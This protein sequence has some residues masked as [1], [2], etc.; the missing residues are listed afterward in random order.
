MWQGLQ[1]ICISWRRT[2]SLSWSPTGAV[3]WRRRTGCMGSRCRRKGFRRLSV[4][5]WS[6]RS[7]M[8]DPAGLIR[9]A[10]RPIIYLTQSTQWYA[11]SYEWG[12]KRADG[13]F[14]MYA[15][16]YAENGSCPDQTV[17]EKSGGYYGVRKSLRLFPS[18]W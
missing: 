1:S 8:T 17:C 3:P 13:I 18:L 4:W 14:R 15:Q 11:V 12:V 2:R 5:I 9:A 7:W 16:W 6:I 10:N